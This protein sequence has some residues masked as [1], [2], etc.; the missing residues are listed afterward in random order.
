MMKM[1]KKA[2]V[3]FLIIVMGF[4]LIGTCEYNA[5]TLGD[6]K[7][8]LKSLEDKDAA[9]KAAGEKTQEEIVISNNKIARNKKSIEDGREKIEE[10]KKEIENLNVE[11][12]E[13]EEQTRELVRFLQIANGE[14]S[15]LEY[16]FGATSMTDLINRLAIVEQLSRYNEELVDEMNSLIKKEEKL[17]KD[18]AKK[19]KD[20][21]KQILEL[22]DLIDSLYGDLSKIDSLDVSLDK[23]IASKK[24]LIKIYEDMGCK[25]NQDLNVCTN[26]PFDSDFARPIGYGTISSLYGYRDEPGI[27]SYHYGIDIATGKTGYKVYASAAGI[28]ASVVKKDYCG[29][30]KIFINHT[31]NGKDYTTTYMHL[32]TVKVKV[33]DVVTK[34]T[35]IALSGGNESYDYCSTGPHLHFGIST[36]HYTTY[37]RWVANSFD[38]LKKVYIP[39]RGWITSRWY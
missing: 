11:I 35:V 29:G 21:E 17:Q 2:S 5:K 36:G 34:D 12:K 1:L 31:V 18:L 32:K 14:N 38:P 37:S 23:Q 20:L 10:S 4:L 8:E 7:K 13:K 19:E 15:Y 33:G 6:L 16:V 9:N 28:V 24:Q 27:S 22:E 25:D 3:L 39:K 30:N 26:M